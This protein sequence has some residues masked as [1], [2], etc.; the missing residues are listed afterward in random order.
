MS[1]FHITINQVICCKITDGW[2]KIKPN[3]KSKLMQLCPKMSHTI[4]ITFNSLKSF[5][6][7]FEN[8]MKSKESH[9]DL[10]NVTFEKKT[11]PQIDP[12]VG[13][14]NFE[15]SVKVLTQK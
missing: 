8:L 12:N 7:D 10:I 11:S 15:R 1:G 6:E 4:K 5:N 13:N 14:I 2:R 3:T 9:N